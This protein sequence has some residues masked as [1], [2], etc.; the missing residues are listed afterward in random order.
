[1]D[2]SPQ[3]DWQAWRAQREAELASPDGWLT[4]VGLHWL[5][6]GEHRIGS[7]PDCEPQLAAGP[8][9]WGRLRIEENSA[10]WQP[11][12]SESRTLRTDVHGQPDQVRQG[13][14]SFVLIERD[15]RIALRLRDT[16]ATT[17]LDFTGVATFPYDPAWRLEAEWDA[18]P[19]ALQVATM[20]GGLETRRVPGRAVL[21][22]DGERYTLT[23]L[24]QDEQG[25]FFVF[26]DQT[27]GR[28]GTYGGGRFLRASLPQDGKLILDFNRAYN[29]PCAFTPYATCPL[30]P[31]ENRLPVAVNAGEKTPAGH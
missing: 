17:R 19:Q 25:L 11:A 20:T 13:T 18:T 7:D 10:L 2:A 23:P 15:G 5:E 1:M 21:T 16:D 22:L 6:A 3:T 12:D 31:P 8:A 29:P 27:S 26:A 24:D 30:A 14:V 28:G 4:L 9:Y